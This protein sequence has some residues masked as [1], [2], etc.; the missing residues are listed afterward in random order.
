MYLPQE[1]RDGTCKVN[2]K[3]MGR[4]PATITKIK[5]NRREGESRRMATGDYYEHRA[6]AYTYRIFP[7]SATGTRGYSANGP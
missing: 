3:K 4:Y 6:D 7:G 1:S 2:S 5:G